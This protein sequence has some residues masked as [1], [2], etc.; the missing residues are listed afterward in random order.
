MNVAEIQSDVFA[1]KSPTF[2][3]SCGH[4]CMPQS[5]DCTDG[6]CIDTPREMIQFGI[7]Q[8]FGIAIFEQNIYKQRDSGPEFGFL[9]RANDR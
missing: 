6:K 2:T 7:G 4:N 1:A 5:F 9:V 8:F 3:L